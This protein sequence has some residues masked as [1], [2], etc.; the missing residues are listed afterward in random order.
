VNSSAGAHPEVILGRG[1]GAD[2]EAIYNLCLILENLYKNHVIS[3]N[4]T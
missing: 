1:G 3:I 2:P 4:V